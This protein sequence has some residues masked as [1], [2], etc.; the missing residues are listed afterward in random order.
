MVLPSCQKEIPN[1]ETIKEL[2]IDTTIH[3][4]AD[5]MLN[6]AP[7]GDEGDKADI[8]D[9]SAQSTISRLENETDMFNTVYHY[10]PAGKFTGR[11]SVTISITQNP[12]GRTL[13]SKDSTIIYVKFTI[14]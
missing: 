7:Y 6:L 11:D 4:G 9:Q 14:Q 5:F 12:S 2:T 13:C 1:S 3:A 8:I 10:K